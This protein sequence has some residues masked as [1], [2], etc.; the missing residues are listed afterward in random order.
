MVTNGDNEYGA[1]FIER[2][3][4]EAEGTSNA[5]AGA[6][7]KEDTSID[8]VALDFYSRYLRI[9]F[10]ACE[11]F[12]AGVGTPPCKRNRLRWCQSDLG[13]A[14]IRWPRFIIE[15]RRFSEPDTIVD[16]DDEHFDGLTMEALLE[17]GWRA[18]HVSDAC[19][20]VHAPSM[21][22]CAWGGGV[23]DD[24]NLIAGEGGRCLT[25]EEAEAALKADRKGLEE[26]HI[27]IASDGNVAV[28]EGA[29]QAALVGARC[30]RRKGHRSEAAW[31]R[32]MLWYTEG[33]V[34]DEDMDAFNAQ[35]KAFYPD[36]AARKAAEALL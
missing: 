5:S 23:W 10:P 20:F 16:L 18:A 36:E 34:D 22:S 35:M 30:I 3:I 17:G 4:Q 27:D 1:G 32:S 19:L 2:V 28:F 33:C 11:R 26:V 13:A 29:N 31:G 15:G 6:A 21:Q 8:I 14:A 24:R 7:P 12:A 25:P 9:T